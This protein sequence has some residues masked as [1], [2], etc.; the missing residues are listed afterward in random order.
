[1]TFL[2]LFAH[3]EQQRRVARELLEPDLSVAICIERSLEAADRDRAVLQDLARPRDAGRFERGAD[4]SGRIG[5]PRAA[6]L[7]LLSARSLKLGVAVAFGC[8]FLV[9]VYLVAIGGW[10]IALLGALSIGAGLGY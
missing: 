6:Q 7:G 10:P 3:V 8:A 5:P 2:A 1:M 9:G 4:S